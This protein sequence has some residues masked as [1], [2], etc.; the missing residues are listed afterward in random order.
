M[1][2]DLFCRYYFM[3]VLPTEPWTVLGAFDDGDPYE[4]VRWGHTL[5]EW[6]RLLCG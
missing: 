3:D 5:A 1:T 6:W 4:I 2:M